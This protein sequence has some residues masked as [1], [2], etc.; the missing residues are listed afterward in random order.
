MNT[1]LDP[2]IPTPCHKQ[3]SELGADELVRNSE[4][5]TT[6]RHC[7]Q[8]DH[9]VHDISDLSRAEVLSLKAELGGKLCGMLCS[10]DEKKTAPRPSLSK[11]F[12]IGTSIAGLALASCS[13]HTPTHDNRP[14]VLGMIA[15]PKGHAVEPQAFPESQKLEPQYQEK[16]PRV[17]VGVVAAEE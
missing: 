9:H 15:P 14:M 7:S 1:N 5:Q 12:I 10:Q 4:C 11:P 13:P 17:W 2:L 6:A 16:A 8:C 3:W